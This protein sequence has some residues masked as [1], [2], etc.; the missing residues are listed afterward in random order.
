MSCG[1]DL[2]AQGCDARPILLDG[3]VRRGVDV[4][5]ALALGARACLIARP[6]L[7]GLA[8]AGEAGVGQMLETL[9]REIERAMGL[10]GAA[11]L[12]EVGAEG[13]WWG[14][15][16]AGPP[17]MVSMEEMGGDDPSCAAT[18]CGRRAR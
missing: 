12:A 15:G 1:G 14:S 16:R 18:V 8:V 4:V 6:Q 17:A 11:R 2:L 13:L 5:K 3:G 9:R 7:W 10:M